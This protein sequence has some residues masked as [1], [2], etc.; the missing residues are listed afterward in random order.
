MSESKSVISAKIAKENTEEYKEMKKDDEYYKELDDHLKSLNEG[1][2]KLSSKGKNDIILK[3]RGRSK[4]EEILKE[5]IKDIIEE[6]GYTVE[7]S[8]ARGGIKAI[9]VSW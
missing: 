9:K 7:N 8:D 5:D 3:L 6:K 4:N 1:I 2:M